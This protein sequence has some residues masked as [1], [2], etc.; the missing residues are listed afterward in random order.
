MQPAPSGWLGPD[1]RT[2][3]ECQDGP[4]TSALPRP[5]AFWMGAFHYR[6]EMG[7]CWCSVASSCRAQ[8]S[9]GGGV[10]SLGESTWVG[11][12]AGM[13]TTHPKWC[14]HSASS[15]TLG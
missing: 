11:P 6:A 10:Q 5:T 15:P 8:C 12:G 3:T 9:L 1:P 7:K 14:N 4:E 13:V 2:L